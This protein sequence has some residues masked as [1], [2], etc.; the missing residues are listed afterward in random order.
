M[1]RVAIKGTPP[2]IAEQ[3]VMIFMTR[4]QLYKVVGV[5]YAQYCIK[6]SIF[7]TTYIIL[8]TSA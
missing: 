8:L 7:T 4:P 1:I 6:Y 2:A 3:T 5:M